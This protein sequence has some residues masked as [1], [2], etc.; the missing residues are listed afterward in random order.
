MKIIKQI[1]IIFSVCW[2]SMVIEEFFPGIFRR[3]YYRNDPAV[4]LSGCGNTE[5]R[6]HSGKG[7]FS[8]GKH[9]LFLYPCG[10]QHH[11]LSGHSGERS[12]AADCYLRCVHGHNFRGDSLYSH[13]YHAAVTEEEKILKELF[14][15]PYFGVALSVITFG[16]GVKL[17]QKLKTP[18]CNPL[19][20]AI[21]LTSGVLLVFRNSL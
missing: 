8:S 2:I 11:Q 4:F 19:I 9:V 7:G 12:G 15:S 3:Q 17:N 13:L 16:I 1:G 21:V 6:T 20:I 18:I 10:G 14:A 5:N